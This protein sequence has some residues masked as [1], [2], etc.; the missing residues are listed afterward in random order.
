LWVHGPAGVGKTTIMHSIASELLQQSN[1]NTQNLN[2]SYAEHP[3]IF[4]GSTFFFSRKNQVTDR[5]MFFS[6]LA[7]GLARHIPGLAPY[8]QFIFDTTPGITEL[9]FK[10]QCDAL[11]VR[12][13]HAWAPFAA[14]DYD[15][16]M[17][18]DG[19]DEC[20]GGEE[21]HVELINAI[22]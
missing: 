6:T 5:R 12:P 9:S 14:N 8:I 10:A 18:V 2:W 13:I 21:A 1:T 15:I 20:D 17:I 16:F 11:I 22:H 4:T 3:A 7:Y 19:L